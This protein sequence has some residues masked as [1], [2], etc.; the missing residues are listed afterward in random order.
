MPTYTENHALLRF[1]GPA[2]S[3][4]EIWSC[5]LRLR[6]IGGDSAGPLVADT[7]ATIAD[8][9]QVVLDYFQRPA[10]LFSAYVRLAWV[11]LN[12]ISSTTGKYLEPNDPVR[13]EYETSVA[14]SGTNAAPQLA[15]CVTLKG[16]TNR[17]PASRGRWYVPYGIQ[18]ATLVTGTGVTPATPTQAMADSAGTFLDDLQG[19]ESGTGPNI[20]SPHLF[21]DGVS[22]PRDSPIADVLV[23]NVLDTQRRRRN[24]LEETYY[25]ATNWP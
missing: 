21:G 16:L 3:D 15:A 22:G 18:A 20:W 4:G 7:E 13:F 12:G 24:S 10:S 1:G 19:V 25:S 6:H 17:G 11:E 9:A 5:G 2:Y 14:G 23:G 8:V